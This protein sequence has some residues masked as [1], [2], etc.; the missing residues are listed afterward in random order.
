[1]FEAPGYV[2]IG[3]PYKVA[4]AAGKRHFE[5]KTFTKGG[6]G[7]DFKPAK[8]IHEKV[9]RPALYKYMEQGGVK[10]KNYKDEEG[11]VITGPRNFT[12]NRL[13]RGKIGKGTSFGGVP[14]HM[15]DDIENNRKKLLRKEI[16]EH[17]SKL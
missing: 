13:K 15:P 7:L 11:G 4:Q 2:S 14:E 10:K 6:H 8:F 1:M 12:T 3:D 5:H 9:P 16:D 17:H